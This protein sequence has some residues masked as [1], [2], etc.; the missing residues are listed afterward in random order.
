MME[1]FKKAKEY[2]PKLVSLIL[3]PGASSTT[4]PRSLAPS[5]STL[6]VDAYT[7]SSAMDG[8]RGGVDFSLLPYS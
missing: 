4:A 1:F 2:A 5:S 6:V 3:P 8:Y 7:P